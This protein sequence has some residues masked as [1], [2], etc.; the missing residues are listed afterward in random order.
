MKSPP[1]KIKSLLRQRLI[2]DLGETWMTS[3]NR[4]VRS[5]FSEE[6]TFMLRPEL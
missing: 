6:V 1:K 5:V 2:K 3:L 4:E